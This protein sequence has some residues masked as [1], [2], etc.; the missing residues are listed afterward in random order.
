MLDEGL[1]AM[2]LLTKILITFFIWIVFGAAGAMSQVSPTPG[3]PW[4][5]GPFVIDTSTIPATICVGQPAASGNSCPNSKGVVGRWDGTTYVPVFAGG[6]PVNGSSTAWISITSYGADP[7]GANDSAPALSL[8]QAAANA[9]YSQ[10]QVACVYFPTGTYLMN[11]NPTGFTGPGCVIGDG[12]LKTIVKTGPNLTTSVFS[13][14]DAW[15]G[16]PGTAFPYNGTTVNI[17]A[18][19]AGPI[20]SD[21]S[22]VGNRTY[23]QQTAIAFDGHEDFGLIQNVDVFYMNGSAFRTGVPA[24]GASDAYTRETR[25]VNFRAFNSGKAGA[26]VID[27][28]TLYNG[29]E[30]SN[31]ID[32]L[33]IDI[34]APFGTGI[35]IAPRTR[36]IEGTQIRVE[37]IE[38]NP[39]GIQ[40]DLI[41]VGDGNSATPPV[42]VHFKGLTL[43]D[44]YVGFAALHMAGTSSNLAYDYAFEGAIGGGNP[45]G[46]GLQLDVGRQGIFRFPANNANGTDLI[47]GANLGSVLIEAGGNQSG[48]TITNNSGTPTASFF[49]ASGTLNTATGVGSFAFGA[50]SSA[51]GAN[52]IVM[53]LNNTTTNAA[54][55][56]LGGIGASDRGR[57]G[58]IGSGASSYF[59][60]GQVGIFGTTSGASEIP[61][62][63]INGF[64]PCI[65][66]DNTTHGFQVS[67]VA[68]DITNTAN[69]FYWSIPSGVLTRNVGASSTREVGQAPVSGG[70]GT[71]LS[72]SARAAADTSG[73]CLYV[74]FQPPSGNTD[75]WH[76]GGTV[77]TNEV[78]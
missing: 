61:L 42:S 7:T 9:K 32:L 23:G 55:V 24:P 69:V 43:I 44:P 59:Q 58:W 21:L 68:R 27:L 62:R 77:V 63:S 3:K 67:I 2:N 5:Y 17:P 73:G 76:V 19:R 74:A 41:Q 51:S 31:S 49:P 15:I 25:L 11:S 35:H 66:T 38:N 10:G 26:P 75:T 13:W 65:T 56:I 45:L 53:G 57:N 4:P 72:A 30:T 29:G 54:N 20:L 14:T 64:G 18:V 37:G 12:P 34:Y 71:G 48:W 6:A 46:N 22:I 8:A 39:S 33:N 28:G 60:F 36:F 78:Q 47:L 50:G 1:I 40:A 16:A 70:F 52:S